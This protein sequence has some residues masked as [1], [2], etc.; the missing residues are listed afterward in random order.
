M[1]Q[2]RTLPS[3][4]FEAAPCHRSLQ[5][6]RAFLPFDL[7]ELSGG[8]ESTWRTTAQVREFAESKKHKSHE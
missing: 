7:S 6:I 8:M 4:L 1:G 5:G 2:E 3:S